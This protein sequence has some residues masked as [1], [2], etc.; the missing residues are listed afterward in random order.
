MATYGDVAPLPLLLYYSFQW[1]L[2][3]LLF[4]S[5]WASCETHSRLRR[6]GGWVSFPGPYI[7]RFSLFLYLASAFLFYIISCLPTFLCPFSSVFVNVL[8]RKCRRQHLCKSSTIPGHAECSVLPFAGMVSSCL[9]GSWQ[10]N[11]DIFG[12]VGSWLGYLLCF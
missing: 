11:N 10:L 3:E 6:V 7:S 1:A 5:G 8:V 4:V 2:D 12:F 9:G